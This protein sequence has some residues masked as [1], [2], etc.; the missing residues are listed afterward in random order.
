MVNP[1]G[2]L[3]IPRLV[4]GL[5]R[6]VLRRRL[7]NL[8]LP[9][10]WKLVLA[11]VFY[12]DNEYTRHFVQV[13]EQSYDPK[14]DIFDVTRVMTDLRL[15]VLR[16]NYLTLLPQISVPVHVI[17]GEEDRLVPAAE[18]RRAALRLPDATLRE[19]PNVGHMPII[20]VPEEVVAFLR[21]ALAIHARAA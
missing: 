10:L 19:L 9:R 14:T 8:L 20:E 4:Q 12:T 7:L 15:E 1:A 2:F 3:D 5:G 18:L 13:Q 21:G 11:N 17:W 6:V 16:R